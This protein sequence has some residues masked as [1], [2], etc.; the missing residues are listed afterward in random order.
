[1]DT[2]GGAFSLVVQLGTR[3]TLFLTW[4]WGGGGVVCVCQDTC[5]INRGTIVLDECVVDGFVRV[6]GL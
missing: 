6:D 5:V 1:M 3:C 2:P 4:T